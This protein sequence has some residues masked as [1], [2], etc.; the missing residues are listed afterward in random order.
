[1]KFN[2]NASGLTSF[3]IGCIVVVMAG[4]GISLL[5]DRRFGF[6]SNEAMLQ[7]DLATGETDISQL[8]GSCRL[9]APQVATSEAN[10]QRF[11]AER[12][13]LVKQ[14][15]TLKQRR[16]SLEASRVALTPAIRALAEEF[17]R[18]RQ[19]YRDQARNAAVG[20]SLGNLKTRAGREFRNAT[21]V[22]VTDVGLEIHHEEGTARVQAPD[23]SDTLRERFQWND[24]ERYAT[25]KQESSLADSAAQPVTKPTT[26]K[27][28]AAPATPPLKV[29]P[30]QLRLARRRVMTAQAQVS[31]LVNDSREAISKATYG[32]EHSVPGSLETW[33][34][35]AARLNS[36]LEKARLE[37][38]AARALLGDLS[39]GDA[40][41]IH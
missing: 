41:L 15:G 1:M 24:E 21:I 12:Q 26:A 5:V 33:Q 27:P 13:A 3:L 25:L 39:P 30:E 29:E 38:T 14:L 11:D 17:S 10:S 7:R 2:D 20:E 34:N 8:Q 23:L 19:R 37:L 18:Y 31:Q 9:L 28:P 32:R 16:D 35:R 4:V 22:R 36:E 6:S 40:L